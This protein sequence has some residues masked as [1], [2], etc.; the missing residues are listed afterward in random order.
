G[1]WL[2]PEVEP[3]RAISPQNIR[4]SGSGEIRRIDLNPSHIKAAED[5]MSEKQAGA[6]VRPGRQEEVVYRLDLEHHGQ[7]VTTLYVIDGVIVYSGLVERLRW[8][9]HSLATREF[10]VG[11][12]LSFRDGAEPDGLTDCLI[13]GV[14][15]IEHALTY[16]EWLAEVDRLAWEQWGEQSYTANSG[17][18]MPGDSWIEFYLEGICA[19]RAW[20]AEVRAVA[21]WMDLP[22]C[23]SNTGDFFCVSSKAESK[24][25]GAG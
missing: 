22:V 17:A 24:R 9:Q 4:R 20:G 25:A 14:Q 18:N 16:K 12:S 13:V 21:T 15:P 3:A 19:E 23:F 7:S 10:A 1:C 8:E 11:D 2:L 6:S 5:A